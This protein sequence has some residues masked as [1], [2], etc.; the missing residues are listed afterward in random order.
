M[1]QSHCISFFFFHE[2]LSI[3]PSRAKLLYC[4]ACVVRTLK[5]SAKI[6]RL[7]KEKLDAIE[8]NEW[9]TRCEAESYRKKKNKWM[10]P[11]RAHFSTDEQNIRVW[12]APIAI[13]S[14][15]RI[16]A[17]VQ[18]AACHFSFVIFYAEEDIKKLFGKVWQKSHFKHLNLLLCTTNGRHWWPHQWH[19]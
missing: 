14:T 15:M 6:E 2:P 3:L 9:W 7:K 5:Q 18:F 10:T 16:L 17:D 8:A 19:G 12:S 4:I 13:A 1:L 11:L